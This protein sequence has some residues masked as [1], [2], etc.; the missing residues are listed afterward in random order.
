MVTVSRSL[1][2][3]PPA[4]PQLEFGV[5]YHCTEERLYTGR[6]GQGAF[7]NGQRLRVSGETGGPSRGK[8]PV[9]SHWLLR[10]ATGVPCQGLVSLEIA[11][12]WRTGRRA[13]L[14]LCVSL[15]WAGSVLHSPFIPHEGRNPATCSRVVPVS[16]PGRGRS[17]RHAL[18]FNTSRW[19][20]DITWVG[21]VA[22]RCS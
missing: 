15:C 2:S 5:I 19:L 1:F 4:C 16:R 6:R 13:S 8:G 12:P 20:D 7:C 22:P 9:K 10:A 14:C 21:A 17:R 3:V 18:A 11:H